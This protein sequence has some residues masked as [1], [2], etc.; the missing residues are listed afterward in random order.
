MMKNT[1][2][3]AV[4]YL[5][6]SIFGIN[7][8]LT[9]NNNSA[10]KTGYAA[11]P[12]IDQSKI[13]GETGDGEPF[14][15]PWN[16]FNGF[17]ASTTGNITGVYD[18]SG[19]AWE[20]MASYVQE[21]SEDK[22]GFSKEELQSLDERFVDVYA[23]DSTTT[24]YN[25]MILGDATGEM[26]PFTRYEDTDNNWRW[27]NSWYADGSHF[28][29]ASNPWF[30]RGGVSDYGVIA[31]QFDFFRYSDTIYNGAGFRISLAPQ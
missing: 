8:E 18:M 17:T 19:G 20:Y 14:N 9:I 26:G 2:W 25:K 5:S 21:S 16:T 11:L 31:G 28:V 6:H 4:A 13:L 30:H 29:E 15:T 1:E 3:G 7:K 27:H 23:K 22:T 24:S 12:T 10:H